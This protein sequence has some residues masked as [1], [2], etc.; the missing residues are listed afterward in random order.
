MS[1]GDVEAT[2]AVVGGVMTA[3]AGYKLSGNKF[4]YL[5]GFKC[6]HRLNRSVSVRFRPGNL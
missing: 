5:Y 3:K 4:T 1:A 6:S 2:I